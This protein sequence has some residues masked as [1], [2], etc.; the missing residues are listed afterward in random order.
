MIK[1]MYTRR[2]GVHEIASAVPVR[3]PDDV[4]VIPGGSCVVGKRSGKN[5]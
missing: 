2:I 3:V 4:P 5:R 1:W